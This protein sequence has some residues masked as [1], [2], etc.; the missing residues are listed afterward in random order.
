M[1]AADTA[2]VVPIRSFADGKTRLA[3][4]LSAEARAELLCRVASGVVQA[5]GGLATA[6]VSSAPEVRGWA[7]RRGLACIDDPGSLNSAADAGVAWAR[8]KGHDRVII[9]HADLP[10]ARTFQTVVDGFAGDDVVL[11][12]GNRDRGTPV[13]AI[14]TRGE[15]G[16]SY[17]PGSFDRHVGEARR[18]RLPIRRVVDAGLATDLDTPDDLRRLLASVSS[19]EVGA[20]SPGMGER[21]PRDIQHV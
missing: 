2:L 1:T 17:G 9:A 14:S 5:S 7:I 11:V 15:F 8:S 3:S 16:F 10:I 20:G 21:Q 19:R 6:I 13:L 18:R 12:R 4:V